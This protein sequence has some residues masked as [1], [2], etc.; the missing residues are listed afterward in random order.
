LDVINNRLERVSKKARTTKNKNDLTE[1]EALKKAKIALEQNKALRQVRFTEDELKSLK[2]YSFLTLKPIIYLANIK[3]S[4]LGNPDNE[5]V[6]EV[7]K[8]AT[9]EN[10]KVVSLCA[11]VEEDLSEL[12]KEEKEEMLEALGLEGSGIDNLIKAT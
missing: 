2:S 7:K 4:E 10:A 3:E 9:N 12:T 11:K 6:K 8:Y 1:L 5:Y